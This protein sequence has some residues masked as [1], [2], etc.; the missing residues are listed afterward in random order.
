MSVDRRAIW[1]WALYDFANSPLTTLV[2][3]FVYATYFTQAIAADARCALFVAGLPLL[4]WVNEREGLE[5]A[6]RS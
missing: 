6:A 3:T 1:S 4:M 2:A 5:T